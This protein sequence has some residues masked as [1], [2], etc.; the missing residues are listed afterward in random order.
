LDYGC[1]H[2]LDRH[3]LGGIVAMADYKATTSGTS[4][5]RTAD[6]ASIPLDPG[7][8]DYQAYLI[9]EDL[10]GNTLD[11][12]DPP[13]LPKSAYRSVVVEDFQTT[14][15]LIASMVL[16]PLA[17]QTLYTARFTILA[18]DTGNGDCRV[19]YAKASAK[20]LGAGALLVGTPSIDTDH[21]NPGA[22][23]WAIAADTGGNNF[24]VRVTGAAGRTIS[25]NL[26][27]EVLRARPT[28]LV[29]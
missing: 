13:I 8:A 20:R 5:I 17:A 1:V 18:I 24:R 22:T 6:S 21:P 26:V 23:G 19:W 29:D 28:G 3:Y 7:N 4:I 14:D 16:W 2:H 15:A 12:A 25:W 27:G 11:P 10:P 9:W